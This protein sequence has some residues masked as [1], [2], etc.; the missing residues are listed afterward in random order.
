M[1]PNKAQSKAV[2]QLNNDVN[3]HANKH[4]ARQSIRC[5]IRDKRRLLSALQQEESAKLIAEKLSL[6]KSIKQAKKVALYLAN[7]GELNLTY[8]I[9]WCWQQN[10]AVYL[11]VIHPFSK[12]HLLFIRY[13]QHSE[14]INNKFGIKE[15][16]ITVPNIIPTKELDIIFTPLVAFDE[17]GNR[18]GMGGGFYD[19]T[20]AYLPTSCRVIGLAHEL[21]KVAQLP[22]ESWDIPLAEI[23]TPQKRY[24]FS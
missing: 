24:I 6:L 11:P 4:T 18:L 21:Q 23:I 15:P 9:N 22:V 3:K 17:Q 5:S 14:M 13:H 1:L 7:D 12:N 19:R 8:F 10:I 16:K 2:N 20:L